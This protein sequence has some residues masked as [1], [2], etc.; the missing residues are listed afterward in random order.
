MISQLLKEE[1]RSSN[2]KNNYMHPYTSK[3]YALFVKFEEQVGQ[4]FYDLFKIRKMS[5]GTYLLSEGEVS[6]KCFYI[7][8]GIARSFQ[9]RGKRE[10]T[11]F[12][13]FPNEFIGSY[14][15]SAL[16]VPSSVSIQLLSDAIVYEFDWSLL[17]KYKLKFPI[18]WKIEELLIVCLLSAFES[19][20]VDMQEKTATERYEALLVHQPQ[21]VKS[22]SLAHIANYIGCT[23]ECI[24]RVRAKISCRRNLVLNL[25][26]SL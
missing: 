10:M 7:K 20:L 11:M 22:V 25:A 9:L 1:V 8:K 17:D 26:E 24:S 13:T 3:L 19:R 21:L 14:R 5:K 15:S 16:K 23:A 12:F 6:T 2:A 18:I 4:E